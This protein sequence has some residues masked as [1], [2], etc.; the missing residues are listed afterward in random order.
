MRPAEIT[1]DIDQVENTTARVGV[2]IWL[3]G[4]RS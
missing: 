4:A 1:I 2:K 3:I